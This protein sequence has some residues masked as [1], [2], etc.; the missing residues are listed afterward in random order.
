MSR[1]WSFLCILLACQGTL[2]Q[3]YSSNEIRRFSRDVGSDMNGM[4]SAIYSREETRE[5]QEE[6]LNL[7][8]LKRRPRP[9][10]VKSTQNH[11]APLFMLDLYRSLNIKEFEDEDLELYFLSDDSVPWMPGTMFNYTLNEVSAVNQAD[12]IMS[13]PVHYKERALAKHGPHRYH[14]DLTRIPDEE[15]VTAA[16]LRVFRYNTNHAPGNGTYRINIYQVIPQD[17]ESGRSRSMAYLD[18]QVVGR[19][20]HGWLVF[21]V[22]M[23]SSTWRTFPRANM[24]LHVTAETLDGESVDPSAIGLV[25]VDSEQGKEPFMV[26]FFQGFNQP[27]PARVRNRR[28][29]PRKSARRR[30]RPETINTNTNSL[31]DL[32]SPSRNPNSASVRQRE[33]QKRALQ[34]NFRDLEWQDWIIAPHGYA[35]FYCEGECAFPLNDYLNATNHAIVQTL[36]NL[37]SPEAVPQACCAPTKLS[38]ISVLFFDDSSNVILKKYRNMVVRA[39]GC[40]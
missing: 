20:D 17:Q 7:L 4:H 22:T 31:N 16:E 19:S 37:M 39:C 15:T 40:H 9:E 35:A 5:I 29:T 34:V 2:A 36:V 32:G 8:G 30:Q 3:F 1:M 38:A 33:C 24:G 18:G 13:L 12:T 14:F 23:A 10:A 6:I 25:G 21:D 26:A 11:S 27:Q 28:S